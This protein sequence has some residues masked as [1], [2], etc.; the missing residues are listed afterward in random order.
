MARLGDPPRHSN[1]TREPAGYDW[2]ESRARPFAGLGLDLGPTT[3]AS[4][5]PG[6]G[7]YLPSLAPRGRR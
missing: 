4:V 7:D 2:G 1:H 6:K 5:T 3:G